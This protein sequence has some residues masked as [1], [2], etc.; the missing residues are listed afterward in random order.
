[1]TGCFIQQFLQAG[2]MVA[3]ECVHAWRRRL[4]LYTKDN[5]SGYN[6]MPCFFPLSGLQK[7]LYYLLALRV[8][9]PF[10]MTSPF[11]FCLSRFHHC[12]FIRVLY[13]QDQ[14]MLNVAM[15]KSEASPI[16]FF[17]FSKCSSP[18]LLSR[19]LKD[20]WR[21]LSNGFYSQKF[22]LDFSLGCVSILS[23]WFWTDD[24]H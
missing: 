13:S 1:M 8:L 16:Y 23:V 22:S 2:F 15:E 10:T 21:Q 24:G 4:P 7:W 20:Y 18:N 9:L 3:L 14:F 6:F 17:I 12:V 11:I 19:W 5:L